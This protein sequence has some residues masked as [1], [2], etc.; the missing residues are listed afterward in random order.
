MTSVKSRI[1]IEI[2]YPEMRNIHPE[3]R[4]HPSAVYEMSIK[5][6]PIVVVLGKPKYNFTDKDVVYFPI[7]SLATDD[8]IEAQVGVFEILQ[9]DSLKIYDDD[10]DIDIE[11]LGEAVLYPYMETSY[12]HLKSD[13]YQILQKHSSGKEL[14]KNSGKDLGKELDKNSGKDSNDDFDD[15][16]TSIRVPREKTMPA[17]KKAAEALESGIFTIVEDIEKPPVLNEETQ[18]EADE[19]QRKY[20]DKAHNPWIQK[21]MKNPHYDIHDVESNGDCFFAVIRDAFHQIGYNTTVAKLRAILA[22]KAD[23]SVFRSYRDIYLEILGGI[24][25]MDAE[26]T[27]IKKTVEKDLKVK[28]KAAKTAEETKEITGLAKEY[29]AKYKKLLADKR[30]QEELIQTTVG[31]GIRDIDTLAKFKEYVQTPGF[32]A[33]EWAISALEYELKIK[34]MLFS[35]LSYNDGSIHTVMNCGIRDKRMPADELFEPK[36]YIMTTYT[37]DHYKLITYKDKRIFAFHEIPYHAKMLIV[38]KCVEQTSGLYGRIQDF[39][40]LLA[41]KGIEPEP[42]EGAAEDATEDADALNTDLYDPEIQFNY[43]KRA[44]KSEAPGKASGEKMV[45]G[46]EK[47][48]TSLK[49]VVDWRKKLDDSWIVEPPI[50]IDGKRWASVAHFV[51]GARYKKGYP[52]FYGLFS[53]DSGSE[54]AKDTK[55]A[56]DANSKSG[57][58]EGTII[59]PA[60]VKIDPDYEGINGRI[61]EERKKALEHKFGDNPELTQLLLMTKDAKLAIHFPKDRL[62]AD[63]ELMK[64]RKELAHRNR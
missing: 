25:E 10:G 8:T 3:D 20:K 24:K 40:D 23:E 37:G 55:M 1:N 56:E 27:H 46:K 64:L 50:E 47:D 44:S 45:K 14:D 12:Q 43:Y 52:D 32:W 33:D 42:M 22:E 21:F 11:S 63:M 30:D 16:A 36:Y 29:N 7:Y 15:D 4:G 19:I 49:R 41:R 17:S 48:Y 51:A 58:H 2:E 57:K 35:E 60:E 6:K 61:I 59:R 9:A 53:L 18:E 62:E 54:I 34:V 28:A 13:V 5:D 26:L 38:N 31:T 39:R